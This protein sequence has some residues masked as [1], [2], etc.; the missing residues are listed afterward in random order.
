MSLGSGS[1]DVRSLKI[2]FQMSGFIR[3]NLKLA[4]LLSMCA[5]GGRGRGCS[6]WGQLPRGQDRRPSTGEPRDPWRGLP[7][8]AAS[9]HSLQG[10]PASCPSI[11]GLVGS[12]QGCCPPGLGTKP[13]ALPREAD[14]GLLSHRCSLAEARAGAKVSVADPGAAGRGRP[15][16]S[17]PPTAL[18]REVFINFCAPGH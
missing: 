16:E 6:G 9:G 8:P 3:G 1:A 10:P 15:W 11:T 7:G 5:L 18:I 14:V 4:L 17:S 2:E 13:P 12:L